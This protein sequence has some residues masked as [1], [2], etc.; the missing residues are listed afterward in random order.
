MSKV[1]G[2]IPQIAIEFGAFDGIYFDRKT[3][4]YR[5]KQT[6][7]AI[8]R[9]RVFALVQANINQQKQDLVSLADQLDSG[10][11][12]LLRFQLQAGELL[13]RIH[14]Q[15]AVLGK[16]GLEKMRPADWLRVGRELATQYFAGK[17]AKSGQQFGI[18]H[19]AA[20]IKK[21]LLS[22]AQVRNS[23][24]LYAESG[25]ASFWGAATAAEQ[26][27][28][29]QYGIRQLGVA[30]HCEDCIEMASQPPKLLQDVVLPTQKCRCRNNCKCTIVAL[31]LEE[32]IARGMRV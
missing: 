7:E 27:A 15:S 31:T 25:K 12:G 4:E 28:G 22:I 3:G 5:D 20:D 9:E 2:E 32:A 17:D 16:G 18:K 19:L 10:K 14:V 8:E 11:I 29:R 1:S 26:E 13:R 24:T 23:L 30:E 6:K 21:G